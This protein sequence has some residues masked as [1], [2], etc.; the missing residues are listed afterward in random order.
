M[1]QYDTSVALT[2]NQI[3]VT[4]N[5]E[6]FVKNLETIPNK[7]SRLVIYLKKCV[8][9]DIYPILDDIDYELLK[10]SDTPIIGQMLNTYTNGKAIIKNGRII[11]NNIELSDKATSNICDI[12]KSG[13]VKCLKT[14]M[15]FQTNLVKNS[16]IKIIDRLH[17]FI[18]TSGLQIN[19]KGNVLAYKAVR[20]NM[21]DKYS[22]T[23]Y[24]GLNETITMPRYEVDNNDNSTCSYGLH[25]C[26]IN[27]LKN[28]YMSDN[29]VLL[30]VEVKPED[31]VSIPV[32]YKNTKARVCEYKVVQVYTNE[33]KNDI[34]A[35]SEV[36]SLNENMYVD[37]KNK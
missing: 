16:E 32:D 8:E 7:L 37:L 14:Y 11:F 18:K 25:V 27:Y 10:E 5:G 23:I 13:D 31:F 36:G 3:V 22:N 35:Q 6:T 15:E 12:L 9:N 1:K 33:E 17:D 26:S 2:S 19:E 4:V 24:N 34:F 20:Q 30:L 28:F 21:Y 29:D